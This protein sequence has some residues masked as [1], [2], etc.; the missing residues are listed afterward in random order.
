MELDRSESN[1]GSTVNDD[2]GLQG[3]VTSKQPKRRFVGRRTAAEKALE[4]RDSN[5]T[6]EE[7]G[8][9]QGVY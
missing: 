8:A 4:Q 6:I 9:I 3:Q 2:S 7:S 5:I 1:L